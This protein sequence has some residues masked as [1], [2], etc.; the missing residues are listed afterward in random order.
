MLI[1]SLFGFLKFPSPF[2]VY[3]RQRLELLGVLVVF[4]R[5]AYKRGVPDCKSGP[6]ARGISPHLFPPLIFTVMA[7]NLFI[8]VIFLPR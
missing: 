7:F 1:D 5:G 6:K 8:F 2:H 4:A 3:Q